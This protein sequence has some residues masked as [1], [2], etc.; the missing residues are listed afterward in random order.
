MLNLNI[1]QKDFRGSTP[2]HWAIFSCSE[3][4]MVYILAWLSIDELSTR[5]DEGYTAMHLA[6]KTS[7]KLDNS[8][9]VRALI[10]HGAPTNVKDSNGHEALDI[11]RGLENPKI[12]EEIIKYLTKRTSLVE[13]LQYRPPLKKVG[14]SWKLPIAYVLFNIYIYTLSFLFTIPFWQSWFE[15]YLVMSSCFVG[16][17]FWIITIN[18]N[19][20]FIKPSP[21]V[22]FLELLQLI[23]PI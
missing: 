7:D 6:I 11:A 10:Y 18:K 22:D 20:G 4:A 14:K 12:R 5:D 17:L 23:D 13:F 8:R 21:N 19:P 3:L 1:N 16:T 15:F 9:P 2:L